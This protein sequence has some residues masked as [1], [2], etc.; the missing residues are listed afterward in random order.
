MID[1]QTSLLHSH[2]S[3]N[4]TSTANQNVATSQHQQPPFP[5]IRRREF[6][7]PRPSKLIN[8]L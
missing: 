1:N 3:T 6:A 7:E 4:K 5:P 2:T 8:K